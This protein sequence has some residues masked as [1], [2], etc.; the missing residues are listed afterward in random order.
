MP[1]ARNLTRVILAASA[2][3][4]LEFF[5]FTVFGYFVAQISDAFF[6]AQNS[7]TSLLYT[8][9]T[10]A[11]AFVARP[12]G[13]LA[14]GSYADRVGRRAAMSL[15]IVLMT[16]GTAMVAF[17]PRYD[18]IGL[19]APLGILCAR[20]LQGFST[21]GEFGGAT[22]FMM[23]H[24]TNRRGFMASFQFTSQVVSTLAASVVAYATAALMPAGALHDWGFRIPFVVGL[25]IGPVGLWLRRATEETPVFRNSTHDARP[26]LTVLRDHPVRIVLAASTI[27]AGT[28]GTYLAIYL[29]TYAQTELHMSASSSFALPML[30]AALSLIVTPIVAGLSDRTHRILPALVGV[31]LLMVAAVPSFLLIASNPGFA[32]VAL[33]TALI[34]VLRAGYSAPIPAMLGELF[35]ASVRGVGMSVSYSLGVLLFG[36]LTPLVNTWAVRTTGLKSFPG[37]WLAACCLVTLCSL[38]A[39]RRFYTLERDN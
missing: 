10:Y 22:A 29:P 3:N 17:M 31:S 11:T 13:A 39:I 1:P 33:A 9:G 27:C 25:L 30:G 12:L 7:T 35:P 24:S 8:W 18:S 6:P 26:A 2:G 28:A 34:A 14:L 15:A 16:L 4:A 38:L 19:L 32:A 5:D 21:G 37:I 20:L 23:E 36:S